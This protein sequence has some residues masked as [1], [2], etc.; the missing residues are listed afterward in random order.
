M[1]DNSRGLADPHHK[2]SEVPDSESSPLHVVDCAARG[3]AVD[4]RGVECAQH[5]GA[6]IQR[7]IFEA[8]ASYWW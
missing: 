3:R 8:P 2:D 4:R 6:R 7:V 1:A 5:V